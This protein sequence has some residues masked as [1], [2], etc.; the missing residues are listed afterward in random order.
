MLKKSLSIIMIIIILLSVSG[1]KKTQED[2]PPSTSGR[3]GGPGENIP[4]GNTPDEIQTPPAVNINDAEDKKTDI[5]SDFT[6]SGDNDITNEDNI[7][8]IT[9]GGEYNLSGKIAEGMV[10]VEA[11]SDAKVTLNL[12]GFSITSTE[13]SPIFIKSADSV[14]IKAVEGSY[15]EIIDAREAKIQEDEEQGDGAIYSLVD[16]T[17]SGSGN[18]VIKGDYNNGVHTKDDLTVKKLTMKVTSVGNA[19]K[20]NDSVSIESGEVILI[21]TSGDG[22]KTKNSSVSSKGNQKGTVSI[23]GGNI[24]IYAACDGI[25]AAYDALISGGNVGINT[26]KY[27]QYSGDV[28]PNAKRDFYIVVPSNIYSSNYRFSAYFYND[29][30]Q[31]GVFADASYAFMASSGGG[32]GGGGRPGGFGTRYYC[33]KLDM[34]SSYSH[35]VFYAFSSNDNNS[36]A[37]YY[38]KSGEMSVNTSFNAFQVTSFSKTSIIGDYTTVSSGSGGNGSLY[39]MKGIKSDNEITIKNGTLIVNSTDDCIHASYGVT[40]ENGA[41]SL[42]NVNISGGNVTLTTADDGIHADNEVNISGGDINILTSYE[43]VEGNIITF[44]GGNTKLYATDDGVNAANKAGKTP[45]IYIKGGYLDVT[46]KTGDTDGIDSNGYLEM[47]GGIVLVKGGSS[48]GNVSGSVDLDRELTVTGGTIIAI[49]G[50]CETPGKNSCNYVKANR[51]S[52][53]AGK[54]VLSD[55]N[56]NTIFEFELSTSYSSVWICSDE[57]ALNQKYLLTKDGSSFMSW[58]QT[59]QA[60]TAS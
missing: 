46:T 6:S 18:L 21:S 24:Q 25:D 8:R 26:G 52:F 3:P 5:V 31:N 36:I 56:G 20:G 42:G 49:G 30:P 41:S 58:T 7:Y 4:G 28:T 38:A 45:Y 32:P 37:L 60:V 47:S 33:L 27:S 23:S 10:I 59:S 19:L 43:G 29:D 14:T 12:S 53:T 15:N 55:S 22:I 48:S 57:F 2:F 54:Y 35:V 9:A 39:S 13:N 1:C 50:I 51:K 11:D 40:L 34:P 16:L 44:S 17:L